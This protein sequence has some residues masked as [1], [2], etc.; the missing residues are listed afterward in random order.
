MSQVETDAVFLVKRCSPSRYVLFP[1]SQTLST[2]ARASL[3]PPRQT[4]SI[5]GEEK[6]KSPWLEFEYL[7]FHVKDQE[8]FTLPNII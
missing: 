3:S 5:A 8:P 7:R 2:Q 1:N 4:W 6:K